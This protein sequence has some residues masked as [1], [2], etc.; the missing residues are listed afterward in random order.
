MLRIKCLLFVIVFFKL[1]V[2]AQFYYSKTH[3]KIEEVNS[4][5][6][7]TQNSVPN[8]YQD[9]EDYLWVSTPNG[10][11]QYD[12][13]FFKE[14]NELTP[15]KSLAT[16]QII[17]VDEDKFGNI[18]ILNINALNVY[19]KRQNK[20]TTIDLTQL[21]NIE[22]EDFL[23]DQFYEGTVWLSSTTNILKIQLNDNFEVTNITSSDTLKKTKKLFQNS[24]GEILCYLTKKII[25]TKLS[26]DGKKLNFNTL[27]WKDRIVRIKSHPDGS[28]YVINEKNISLLLTDLPKDANNS[29]YQKVL[30]TNSDFK[31]T[32]I[33]DIDFSKDGKIWFVSWN[34]AIG[35]INP[36]DKNIKII[37]RFFNPES[38]IYG[39]YRQML[40]D[41]TGVLWIATFRGGLHKMNLYPKPFSSI[42]DS[43]TNKNKVRDV[44]QITGNDSG[45]I[46]MGTY[47]H[48]LKNLHI[49]N[50]HLFLNTI[51]YKKGGLNS[52]SI[53]MSCMYDGSDN[54]LWTGGINDGVQHHQ[55]DKAGKIR[56]TTLYSYKKDDYPLS[57]ADAIHKDKYGNIWFGDFVYGGI[58]REEKSRSN[59]TFKYIDDIE[60]KDAKTTN[61]YNSED[62]FWI[63]TKNKGL[64]R[65]KI[66][67]DG[68]VISKLNIKD[69]KN[70][71]Q[72]NMVFA[73]HEDSN[74]RIWIGTFGAGLLQ[75]TPKKENTD[76]YNFRYFNTNH[77][78][79]NNGVY[80][81]LEDEELNLWM[82]TDMG[83]SMLDMHTNLFR[84]FNARDGLQDNNFRKNSSWKRKDGMLFFGGEKG[85]TFFDPKEI[86]V[87]KT[88]QNVNIT[89][90]KI[91]AEE[92]NINT[93]VTHKN[94][95]DTKKTRELVLEPNQNNFSV[96]F[97][98]MQFDNPQKSNY[99]Y[100]LE[101]VDKEWVLTT[102]A[103][104]FASYSILSAGSYIFK[105]KASNSDGVWS[106]NYTAIPITIKSNWYATSWAFAL[107]TLLFLSLVFV[108]LRFQ[109]K[110][111]ALNKELEIEK[112]NR[113]NLTKLNQ[114]KLSFFTN[115]SHEL[116]N[117]LTIISNTVQQQLAKNSKNDDSDQ[118]LKILRKSSNRMLKLITQLLD[119]RKVETGHLPLKKVNSDIVHFTKELS[120][121][122]ESYAENSNRNFTFE[123]S[124]EKKEMSFDPDKLEKIISNLFDNAMK[125]TEDQGK[126]SIRIHSLKTTE[127]PKNQELNPNQ[128]YIQIQ[129]NDD[130]IGIPENLQ[131]DIFNSFFQ[132]E[133]TSNYTQTNRGVG[134]GL[135]FTKILVEKHQGIIY[136]AN[137]SSYGGTTF[138]VVLPVQIENITDDA[139]SVTEVL[140][141]LENTSK[142]YQ[143]DIVIPSAP[144]IDAMELE[145]LFKDIEI[146]IV[147]DDDE[148][149]SFLDEF[150][151][152]RFKINKAS[153][154]LEGLTLALEH[155]PDIIITDVIMPKMDGY[156]MTRQLKENLKTNHI[157]IIMLT[158]NA[159]NEHRIE[160]I[161]AGAD[162][163]IPKPFNWEHLM[164]RIEKLVDLRLQLKK[165]YLSLSGGVKEI[166]ATEVQTEEKEFILKVQDIIEEN[167]DNTEFTVSQLEEELNFG[168]MQLFRK[169]KSITGLSSVEFIRDYRLR[170]SVDL[171]HN[172]NNK[173]YEIVYKCGFSSPS[174]YGKCFKKKYGKTPREFLSEI[175]AI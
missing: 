97:S 58:V 74:K 3:Y 99:L 119:F 78:L 140:K 25:F 9:N 26:E 163:F 21:G 110:K 102:S 33:N 34:E 142:Q 32:K 22:F 54:S 128:E 38:H 144:S 147:E 93:Y 117:P 116:K 51:I 121:Y 164:L 106:D 149:R 96:E 168:R 157:P 153:N 40:I 1:T 118:Y 107:Y 24:K 158:A 6:G 94:T 145:N 18:W 64:F 113:E 55:L 103:R 43:K 151:S 175:R 47:N 27:N 169:I 14:I 114:T 29:A 20:I 173:I 10:L 129:V 50:K 172:S 85:L 146:L 95:S 8:I 66:D 68:R 31:T 131:E 88:E 124:L 166:E 15:S 111:Q 63:G 161:K 36:K 62:Y 89:K 37:K 72:K 61:F 86:V 60:L 53:V 44:N 65:L 135:A 141:V 120:Q 11:F 28:T 67:E 79:S 155:I 101:G 81:I 160:G 150:L 92:F 75:L 52:E 152:P 126:I 56:K 77:G 87:T 174:Y 133:S 59:M 125:H 80:S 73:I 115:I 57:R 170:R 23:V 83:I 2:N 148:I 138:N 104:R 134:I 13:Y 12:G 42:V 39:K 16:N 139:D 46:W 162:S 108:Y 127:L 156:E 17:K 98:A 30:Y 123:S 82:S 49:E 48:G 137:D 167:L 19:S 5:T 35:Y 91:G 130:G 159:E 122:F 132:F 69:P 105:V 4:S 154:G 100:K 70:V 112:L 7:F 76:S 71:L 109:A 45:Q 84:N 136:A 143:E 171:M 90:F 41:K 165:K